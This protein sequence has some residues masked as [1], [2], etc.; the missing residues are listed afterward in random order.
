MVVNEML[1]KMKSWK[2]SY[3]P[4][5]Q[6]V[7]ECLLKNLVDEFRYLQ[8]YPERELMRTAELY[9]GILRE[10]ILASVDF[11]LALRKLLEAISVDPTSNQWK[12]AVCA[13][14]AYRTKLHNYPMV[15]FT[16]PLT[17]TI[18]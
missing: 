11:A 7:L 17:Q 2:E 14:N 6:R 9:G 10:G 8:D 18:C 16:L 1:T 12:F 5:E 3:V 13:L 15:S 4:R